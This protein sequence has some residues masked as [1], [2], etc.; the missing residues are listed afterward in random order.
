MR[1]AL[2]LL[3]A[4]KLGFD[5]RSDAPAAR[6]TIDAPSIDAAID[7]PP[8]TTTITFGERPTSQRTIVS[9][10]TTV[11]EAN[12]TENNGAGEDLALEEE[13][14]NRF[15]GLLRFDL[16]SVAPATQLLA[17]RVRLARLDYGDEMNGAI[18]LYLVTESWIEGTGD[19][20]VVVPGATWQTRD[21][22]MPWASVGGT[23]SAMLATLTPASV[24]F[25]IGL[26]VAVVQQWIDDPLTNH[27]VLLT[28]VAVPTHLHL[29]QSDSAATSLRPELELVLAP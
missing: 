21:G 25:D 18:V 19:G 20:M 7:T 3:S 15:H 29:H 14:N 11:S 12:P 4:C 2:L 9:Y 28:V 26:P 22:T 10:D 17:A 13:P 1:R 27:G 8:G 5:A 16:T 6:D 24:A 23:I